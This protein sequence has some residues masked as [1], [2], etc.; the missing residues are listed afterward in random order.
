MRLAHVNPSGSLFAEANFSVIAS[1]LFT[2]SNARTFSSIWL[3]GQSEQDHL[4][5]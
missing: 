4:E 1:E 5:H 3:S 2:G